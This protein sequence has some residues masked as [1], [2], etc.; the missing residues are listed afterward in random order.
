MPKDRFI[1]LR[2]ERDKAAIFGRSSPATLGEILEQ[3]DYGRVAH[4]DDCFAASPDDWGTY[5][6]ADP[7]SLARQKAYLAAENQHMPQGG[8]TCSADSAAQPLIQCP[9]AL[10]E[11]A[12]L[13]W[14]QI[15]SEYHPAVIKLWRAQGC[16]GEI[17][18]RLGYRL[19]LVRS[20]L[21]L[22]VR[23]GGSLSGWL[24]IANDGFAAPYNSRPVELVLRKSGSKRTIAVPLQADP[25]L[26]SSG[27]EHRVR[28]AA[29]LPASVARG[30]YELLLNLPDAAPR[31]RGRSAY[32]IRLANAGTWEAATGYNRLLA[33]VDVR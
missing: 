10:R 9:N 33:A 16:Y 17:A 29:L 6:P 11:L 13:H 5:R 26:W 27:A 21:P 30:R 18:R 12:A 23:A 7:A 4:H 22:R 20:R 24:T 3:S 15:N 19:R 1:A 25:R 32:S 14:S 28:V 8:E 31:L 2:Y